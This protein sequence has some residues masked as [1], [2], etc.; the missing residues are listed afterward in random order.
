MRATK[1]NVLLSFLK[2]PNNRNSRHLN[3][4]IHKTCLNP[5]IKGSFNKKAFELKSYRA[6]SVYCKISYFTSLLFNCLEVSC[7]TFLIVNK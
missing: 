2:N 4:S 5:T 3:S 6:I 7:K 1:R